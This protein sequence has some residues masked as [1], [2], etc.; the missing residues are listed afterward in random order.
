MVVSNR[1]LLACNIV[2]ICFVRRLN[3]DHLSLQVRFCGIGN[4][5]IWDFGFPIGKQGRQSRFYFF[6][7]EVADYRHFAFGARKVFGMD[8]F[9]VGKF[10]FLE[11]LELLLDGRN[12]SNVPSLVWAK[13]PTDSQ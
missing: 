2:C 7:I 3:G 6:W 9:N 1:V 11:I 12:V 4:A 10:K 13:G 8:L 5:L